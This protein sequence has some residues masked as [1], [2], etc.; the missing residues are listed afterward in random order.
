MNADPRKALFDAASR[1]P[2]PIA[3]ALIAVNT[4]PALVFGRA[5]ARYRA[6]LRRTEAFFDPEPLLLASVERAVANVPHYQAAF[7]GK[8]PRSLREFEER[9]PF[10]DKETVMA[11]PGAFLDPT[12]DRSRYDRGTTGGTSGKPM[13]L[14]APRNRHVVEM[15][16]MHAIWER[17]GWRFDVRAVVRNTRLPNGVPFRVNPVTREFVFDGFRL[18]AADLAAVWRTIRRF[19]I[20]FVHAYPSAAYELCAFLRRVGE[21]PEPVIAFLSGSEN[22]FPHQR[23]LIRGELGARFHNWYGHSEKLVL[24]GFCED[25]EATDYHVEPT[26]GY[27]ELIGDDGS[28]VREPGASGEIVGTS[29]H[30][31]GMPLVRYRTGDIATFV[32]THCRSCGRRLPRFRDVHGRWSGDRVYRADGSFVTTT[33]LNLHD[34]LYA[35]VDGI[36]YLQ[37]R[38]GEI[39]VLVV[40]NPRFDEEKEGR[41]LAHFRERLGEGFIVE[42]RR[43][44]RLHR[45][46][47][48]KFLHLI[49]R[50]P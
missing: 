4:N 44:E 43:V 17:A 3:R 16:T 41:L 26:Y 33:A 6:F 47:N 21:G 37:E 32:G 27:F 34:D 14:F 1:L 49:R 30:N 13:V 22:V 39:A 12:I 25:P 23:A 48:G 15:A 5:Y 36:Q 46:P 29:F 8:P 18:A 28:P 45:Q 50:I 38:H 2:V 40:P 10:I 19:G 35:V 31:P 24:A 20:R 7:R 9:A 42:V 11:D